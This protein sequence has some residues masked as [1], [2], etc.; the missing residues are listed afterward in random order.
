MNAVQ[1]NTGHQPPEPKE[2]V[3]QEMLESIR[4]VLCTLHG[5]KWH[6]EFEISKMQR[7]Q[8][9]IINTRKE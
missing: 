7:L 8:S 5:M 2:D 4:R 9:Q 6:I 3:Q 1:E